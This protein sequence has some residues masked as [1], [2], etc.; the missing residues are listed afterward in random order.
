MQYSFAYDVTFV[1]IVDVR[2]FLTLCVVFGEQDLA[3]LHVNGNNHAR[4]R[5]GLAQQFHLHQTAIDTP[6]CCCLHTPRIRYQ[7]M[8]QY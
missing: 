6:D 1:R 3:L 5:A 2:E 4:S 8:T 7:L